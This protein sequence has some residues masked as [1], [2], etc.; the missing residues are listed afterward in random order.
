MGVGKTDIKEKSQAKDVMVAS[1]QQTAAVNTN[2]QDVRTQSSQETRNIDMVCAS[3]QR[4]MPDVYDQLEKMRQGE[5]EAQGEKTLHHARGTQLLKE[6][7]NVLNL[8]L[9]SNS[10]REEK[11]TRLQVRSD[12]RNF[13]LK[14]NDSDYIEENGEKKKRG[15]EGA[16]DR[17]Y[18]YGISYLGN[19]F[20]SW[21]G[22]GEA[23]D[24][25]ILLSG[26]AQAGAAT[27]ESAMMMKYWVYTNYPQYLKF[28]ITQYNPSMSQ[29]ESS[30][31]ADIDLSGN[32]TYDFDG[33]GAMELGENAETTVIYSLS[34]AQSSVP[35]IVRGAK[36]LI[37]T[38]LDSKV[39]LDALN[40]PVK[41]GEQKA[42]YTD[43]RTGE[44][45]RGSGLNELEEGVYMLDQ[46]RTL[47][48]VNSPEQAI[49]LLADMEEQAGAQKDRMKL[50][51]ELVKSWFAAKTPVEMAA[52][53]EERTRLAGHKRTKKKDG[54]TVRIDDSQLMLDV[55]NRLMELQ[56]HLA[57]SAKTDDP[58]AEL[59]NIRTQYEELIKSC[60]TYESNKHP[61][62]SVGR[63]R[64]NLVIAV[65]KRA[66]RVLEHLRKDQEI[67][68]LKHQASEIQE[69]SISWK[70]LLYKAG[71]LEAEKT[72]SN[73]KKQAEQQ[74]NATQGKK[75]N[76]LSTQG[77]KYIRHSDVWHSDEDKSRRLQH[78]RLWKQ[79]V[80]DIGNISSETSEEKKTA[81][82]KVLEVIRLHL[83]RDVA[84]TDELE[85]DLE[86]KNACKALDEY[87]QKYP[88]EYARMREYSSF[89]L[90]KANGNLPQGMLE[91]KKEEGA[92]YINETK[93]EEELLVGIKF[94]KDRSVKWVD[95]TDEPLFWHEPSAHEIYQ[96]GLGDCYWLSAIASL[97]EKNPAK[98]KECMRDNGDGTVTVR[99]FK[100]T[101]KDNVF[102]PLYV[103]VRK[104]VARYTDNQK[105]A[106]A[107]GRHLW[108]QMMEK[109]YAA[110]G[111]VEVIERED[112][113]RSYKENQ[114]CF[115]DKRVDKVYTE[116]KEYVKNHTEGEISD[117]Q[118]MREK[119]QKLLKKTCAMIGMGAKGAAFLSFL[120]GKPASESVLNRRD[121]KSFKRNM[122]SEK[123]DPYVASM[124]K[125]YTNK[126]KKDIT[127]QLSRL[128]EDESKDPDN[129]NAAIAVELETMIH[130]QIV[131]AVC[132]EGRQS[133]VTIE[134]TKRA[135]ISAIDEI[136]KDPARKKAL[137][138]KL[139]NQKGVTKQKVDQILNN[140]P[141]Y[142]Q[143]V[144]HALDYIHEP[145]A[146]MQ[147]ESIN[148][149]KPIV[150]YLGSTSSVYNQIKEAV[151]RP[152]GIVTAA[153]EKFFNEKD[154]LAD[155]LEEGHTYSGDRMTGGS[156]WLPPFLWLMQCCWK[157]G[158]NCV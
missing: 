106:F 73:D 32:E 16:K 138:D 37:L 101:E 85:S 27:V 116:C 40:Q 136:K 26:N 107:L 86:F 6:G 54:Q 38:S 145:F 151:S 98:I 41:E 79:C 105:D 123:D 133:K 72:A 135:A 24:V 1:K 129:A 97:A 47:I 81:L 131:L 20:E 14:Y 2:V 108:V 114:D 119:A 43:A 51:T 109:A 5:G 132:Y 21:Q 100:P 29:E 44:T 90:A 115:G 3:V 71:A 61:F 65:R 87:L 142:F 120:T 152:D 75:K 96:G 23:A 74:K 118:Q 60:E 91:D 76:R 95:V 39:G 45:Y 144:L 46:N 103:T 149:G 31:H 128:Y 124:K 94:R 70:L 147:I 17:L 82:G 121:F 67:E 35:Q 78:S 13:K 125:A 64:K 15:I 69:R 153:T 148:D 48:R 126:M 57:M 22:P 12:Q 150:A 99:F 143:V 112:R 93:N 102:H 55:K 84:R 117:S 10:F 66:K 9:V 62:T 77:I 83:G 80:L 89:Y 92:E 137:M 42:V 11:K 68:S 158:Q 33:Q 52:A 4:A 110:S 104:S 130:D 154:H 36:R 155:G 141:D 58:Q 25:H 7:K 8:D 34:D 18:N 156:D 53:A 88:E 157:N 63:E 19:L 134:E 49:Y 146:T 28:E 50:L 59:L 30:K 111:L 140:F 56:N 127:S 122:V 139:K 113:F